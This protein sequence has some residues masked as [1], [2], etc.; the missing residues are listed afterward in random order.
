MDISQYSGFLVKKTPNTEGG[1]IYVRFKFKVVKADGT[2][3]ELDIKADGRTLGFWDGTEWIDVTSAA[4]NTNWKVTPIDVD[5][6]IYI[7]FPLKEI[8]AEGTTTVSDIYIYSSS[9]DRSAIFENWS[10]VK[11]VAAN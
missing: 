9:S 6:Y 7:A 10:L 2:V 3:K 1:G 5:G 11:T 4:G 8:T